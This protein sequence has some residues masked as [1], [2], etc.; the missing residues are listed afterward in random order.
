MKKAKVTI[1][2]RMNVGKSTLFNRLTR[3]DR[4]ITSSWP[5]TT[6]DVSTAP[7]IWRGV[8]F[9]LQD[10]GGLDVEDDVQLEERV[11][12]AAHRAMD[13][14]D[15]ILFAVDG[16]AGLMPQDKILA[17]EFQKAKAPVI[18]VVNKVD[19][20]TI[21]QN[22]VGEF[23]RLNIEPIYF[24]S[25]TNGR[26]TGDLL[27][28]IYDRIHTVNADEH[29]DDKRTKVAIVGRPNVGKS[30]FLNAILGEERVIVA[31]MAHTTRDT[32]D[33]PYT[34]ND[35]EFLLIDTAGI[36]RQVNVGRRWGDKRL[37]EIE[38]QSV[39]ASIHAMQRADVVL[40]MMESQMRITAQDKKI[41][42]LA[43][44]YGK[45]L[46]LVFNKWDLIP[47]KETNT[48]NEFSDYFDQALP[49]LRWAPMIF[50]SATDKKRVRE[51][52]DLVLRVT[53]NYE[54]EVPQEVLDEVLGK[55]KGH[56]NPKQSR[57]RKFKKTIVKFQTL[58]QVASKPPHFYLQ[59]TKPKDVP[60]ALPRIAERELRAALD[61]EGVRLIIEIGE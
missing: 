22:S 19:K 31:D 44:E 56:Y 12:A 54:R 28:E 21:F 59:V 42:D 8:E 41:A 55:T 10:T 1:V 30:S 6:R 58:T 38:K 11:I 39:S 5:G 20:E 24:V 60:R 15:L 4:A 29:V 26:G 16:R 2:G 14:S 48:I 40:L 61:F 37:G 57:T 45:A 13:E 46:I 34:Y 27:D 36:R 23:H 50:T 3:S 35:K 43:N 7:V 53:E 47:E 33:I 52:L 49:Y 18:L 9:D 32:N 25:A 51:T 17:R